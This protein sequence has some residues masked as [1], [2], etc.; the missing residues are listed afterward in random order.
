MINEG[1]RRPSKSSWSSPLHVVTKED[2][3]LRI[4]GD[5]CR[6]NEFTILDRYAVPNLMDFTTQ[7]DGKTIFI[8]LD[9]K[10]H[11]IPI[12]ERDLEKTAVLIPFRLL[13]YLSWPL[14]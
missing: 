8:T 2:E 1:I 7:L 11:D 10:R 12:A 14:V 6:L 4:C 13:E 9:I 3:S 5:Y